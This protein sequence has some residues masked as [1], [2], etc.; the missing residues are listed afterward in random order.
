MPG[1]PQQSGGAVSD[2][3]IPKLVDD[4]TGGEAHA[5]KATPRYLCSRFGSIS[6]WL[7]ATGA[8]LPHAGHHW[9]A[10]PLGAFG[11]AIHNEARLAAANALAAFSAFRRPL[12]LLKTVNYRESLEI[13]QRDR[14]PVGT[15][16]LI[17]RMS[18][19]DHFF[20]TGIASTAHRATSASK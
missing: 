8:V 5:A 3:R 6:A 10:L 18:I 20:G 7:D 14:R 11:K 15:R 16:N 1:S 19:A 12:Y 9:S 17:R 4:R 2:D 13:F